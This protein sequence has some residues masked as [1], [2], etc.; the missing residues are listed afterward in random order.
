MMPQITPSL[1]THPLLPPPEKHDSAASRLVKEAAALFRLALPQ[2]MTA[3]LLHSRSVIST[4]FLGR[5]GPLPLAGG[6]LAVAF[7]NITG[8]SILSGLAAGMEPICSQSFGAKRLPLLGLTL[9]RA[10]LLLLL[11]S[12]PISLLWLN[13][14]PLLLL[15]GQ[16]PAIAAQAHTFLLHSL[17][18]LLALSLLHP[19]R[20]YLRSQSITLPLTLSAA[21]SLLLHLPL[22]LLLVDRLRLGVRGVAI[23]SAITNLNTL[24]FLLSF[25]FFT[26]K[27]KSTWFGFSKQALS[28]WKPLLDLSIP[29]CISISLEWWWYELIILLCGLLVHPKPAVAAMGILIQTTALI[30]AFPSSLSSSLSTRVGNE[31]G[32]RQPDRAKF[33]ALVGL[34]I[35][36]LLGLAALLFAVSVRNTWALMFTDDQD[37]IR[38]TTLVLPIIGLCELGNCT[39]TTGCGV[40]RGTARPN[41]A[42]NINLVCFYGVGM[43]VAVVAAF[44]YKIGFVGLWIGLLAAQGSCMV[45]MMVVLMRTDWEMEARRGEEL[46]GE[47]Q[48]LDDHQTLHRKVKPKFDEDCIC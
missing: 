23:G 11:A 33:A 9:Q 12:L 8:Y 37:I 39:Q 42:A 14:T 15:S 47:Y 40:L 7:A 41:V 26:G 21:A 19:L 38:L 48:I 3:L 36:F 6:A 34:S 29:S 31:I 35:S 1:S 44:Y 20:I 28:G 5:L 45:T 10:T 4:L 46:T 24:L 30:Y 2:L 25:L 17:P 43:P 22:N 27:H 32:A 16:D 18:D 13:I